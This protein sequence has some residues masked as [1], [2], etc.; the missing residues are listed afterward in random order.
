M[1]EL[2]LELAPDSELH[3]VSPNTLVSS[4]LDSTPPLFIKQ[5]LRGILGI[6]YK[7]NIVLPESVFETWS[8]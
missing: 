2:G 7:D 1:A 8:L 5:A 3:C 4:V 6:S